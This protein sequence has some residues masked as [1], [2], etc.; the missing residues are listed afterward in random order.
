MFR[1]RCFIVAFRMENEI[2]LYY[3]ISS[4]L[5]AFTKVV[6]PQCISYP[7]FLNMTVVDVLLPEHHKLFTQNETIYV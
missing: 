4:Q 2:T 1:F 6:Y 3:I 5:P 7:A